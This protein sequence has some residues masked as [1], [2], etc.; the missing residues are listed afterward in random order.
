MAT[1]ALSLAGQVVGGAVGG[2]IGATIGRALGALA[3]SAIDSS[4]FGGSAAKPAV[5][6]ADIR[7]QG[8]SEGA[9][10]PKLYGWSRLSGNIIWATELERIDPA[11]T[12]A[13]GTSQPAD[14]PE[15][16]IVANFAIGLCEGEVHRLGR[17]WADG[18]ALELEGLTWRF[19][20]GSETQTADSL[21]E[22][23]QGANA[24][25]Y[26]GLCYIVFERL[27][28]TA[29]GNRIPNI[30]VE[31]CR[32][33]GELEP[34]IEAITVIPGATEFGYDPV[35]RL[36]LVSPGT[37]VSENAHQDPDV[38]DWTLSIDELTA[39]CPNLK[40]VSLVVAWFGDDL[41]CGTCTIAPKVEAA[42]RTVQDTDWS[43][44]GL[45]RSD[46]GVVSTHDGGPAYGG[47]PSDNAVLAAIA[48]LKARGIGVTLYPILL[49]DIP[50]GN[51]L[52]QPAYP[53]RGRISVND[54]SAGT[55]A[56]TTEL[57]TWAS[58]YREF[59]LHYALLGASA[60]G[61]D[62]FI[63]GSELRGLTTACDD[64]GAFPFVSA[65]VSLAA[66]VRAALPDATLTY[67]ADWS[68]YSGVQTGSEKLFHLDP[69]W[70][71]ANIDAVGI[72]NY[73]PMADWRDGGGPD[74]ADWD[75]PYELG[76]LD[77]NIAGGEDFD[78]YYA[79]D[80]DRTAGTRTPITDGT[81]GEPW[82]WRCKDLVNW[83]SNAHHDRPGGVRSATATAW[84]PK[85]KPIWFTELGCAA[86]DKG[87]NQ[88]NV[89]V[90]PKSAESGVP[91][92]STGA[93]DALAQRQVLRAALKHWAAA[94]NNP[95]SDVYDGRRV[96]RT[97]LWT[98]DARPYPAFPALT[99]VWSDGGNRATEHWLTGRLGSAASD[100][101]MRAVAADFGVGLD[102]VAAMRPFV[103]GYVIDQ[104]MTGRAALAPL[105]DATGLD[106][107]DTATGLS[108]GRS[109]GRDPLVVDDPVADALPMLSR[110]RPDPGEAIGQV[111]L[112]YV[113]RAR[114]YQAGS[115]TAISAGSG[116]LDAVNAGLVLDVFGA[117]DTAE[118]LLAA[119]LARPDGVEF[120][121]PPSAL[122]LEV[123]DAVEVD[124]EAF[125]VT[126]ISDGVAR[127]ISARSIAPDIA[128]TTIVGRQAPGGGTATPRAVPVVDYAELPPT[129]D[130]AT[131]ARLAMGAFADPWPGTIA[132]TD[133]LTG[134]RL[135]ALPA[136]AGI[137]VLTAPLG[138]GGIFTWDEV[139]A[140]ELTLYAGHLSSR[141]DDEVL[142]G[143]NRVAVQNDAGGWEIVGFAEATLVGTNAYELT[144]LLRGQAGSDFAVGATSAGNAVLVLD[145]QATTLPVPGAW[146]G[147]TAKIRSFAGPADA[148]G[149]LAEVAIGLDP[150]LPL[151]PA[152]L[153]AVRAVSG[154][155]A[156]SWVRRSRADTDSWAPDDAPLEV[157][158]EAYVVTIFD[159]LTAIRTIN[160][161]AP[162]ATYTAAQQAADF[163]SLPSSF[164][165]GAAQVSPLYGPGHLS[166]ATFTA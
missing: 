152:H 25:A 19:Y 75:G 12:G 150:L 8:S 115:V 129:P 6:G 165:F 54:G 13:K 139:N 133:D 41:R 137:G 40:Q 102:T 60:G 158:P 17:V 53:W 63:I 16:T 145:A 35:A 45:G 77:A 97:T 136:N 71:S 5:A 2:P 23:K 43:V 78:W 160:C 119:D 95:A 142:A 21:I 126:G 130:D 123:G 144:R 114:D 141:D 20:R 161:S 106:V 149:Q 24:P 14:T 57:A 73:M 44:A 72:D 34:L 29:F 99:D 96:L 93:P 33:V 28:L 87:A 64:T 67:A 103:H 154:D 124:G 135:A 118:R 116:P 32:V 52:G 151:A 131:R 59:I 108:I 15:P 122:A 56:A 83:W 58:R 94:A 92:F 134:S 51:A 86:V 76:Y 90:D 70:A 62:G 147:T 138:S 42:S 148:S 120:V 157:T 112:S 49:L 166:T 50:E 164:G 107:H 36:R 85:G 80:A 65:L 55:A 98:W 10:I 117:R 22:A 74:A 1:L 91:Y 82:V 79:S 48:D 159:G 30:T 100:E 61:V 143:A 128:V 39:L 132:V 38:S 47:T 3:G 153:R 9:P 162:S 105:L 155:V 113:D 125:E 18:Q 101:L 4:L 7:L 46:V 156:L 104:P 121:A 69:L 127:K 89:F 109:D 66:D 11:A 140:V 26:R 110:R 27:P 31:L 163:G 111:A 68:E 88:P 84:V 146:V 37:T 81:Y